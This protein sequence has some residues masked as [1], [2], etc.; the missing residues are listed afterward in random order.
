MDMELN[1]ANTCELEKAPQVTQMRKVRRGQCWGSATLPLTSSLLPQCPWSSKLCGSLNLKP[2]LNPPLDWD[3]RHHGQHRWKQCGV[4]KVRACLLLPWC[5]WSCRICFSDPY[6]SSQSVAE[7]P[8][9]KSLHFLCTNGFISNLVCII[10]MAYINVPLVCCL[11]ITKPW[12]TDNRAF[13]LVL[14]HSVFQE[15]SLTVFTILSRCN[16]TN[17]ALVAGV[18]VTLGHKSWTK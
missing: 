11:F 15:F 10:F 8:S 5:P 18:G 12:F 3:A 13:H 16:L 14:L 2:N 7:A 9:Q 4:S 17:L 1:I 6:Q